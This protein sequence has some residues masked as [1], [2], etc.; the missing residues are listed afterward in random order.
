MPP[1]SMRWIHCWD[2]PR[3]DVANNEEIRRAAGGARDSN[4]GEDLR[5][6]AGI[7]TR[8]VVVER[9]GWK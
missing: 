2:R 6:G 9:G 3:R 7:V 8:N 4:G 5:P 1:C